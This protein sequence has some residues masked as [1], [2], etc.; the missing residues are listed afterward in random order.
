MK[1]RLFLPL[2]IGAVVVAIASGFFLRERYGRAPASNLDQIETQARH[3]SIPASLPRWHFGERHPLPGGM[4]QCLATLGDGTILAAVSNV[5][6][7]LDPAGRLKSRTVFSAPITALA[8]RNQAFAVAFESSIE[9]HDSTDGTVRRVPSPGEGT[10][11]IALAWGGSEIVAMDFGH[12]VLWRIRPTGELAGQLKHKGGDRE[13]LLIL[14]SPQGGLVALPDGGWALTNPG[15][16]RVEKRDA[17]GDLAGTFGEP[18]MGLSQF[19]GC[20]NPVGLVR[21]P[22]GRF[23][24]WQK[25]LRRVLVHESDGPVVSVVLSAEQLGADEKHLAMAATPEGN[26]LITDGIRGGFSVMTPPVAAR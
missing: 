21:L 22:N 12:R 18:G 4:P 1:N 2:F 24:T 13:G 26:L 3:E 15:R 14:P 7:R 6:F 23:V 19:P 11:W 5:L 17:S 9:I 8:T 10:R 25:G 20:C 16:L